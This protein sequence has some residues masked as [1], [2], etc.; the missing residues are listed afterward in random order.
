MIIKIKHTIHL[1][2]LENQIIAFFAGKREAEIYSLDAMFIMNIVG[3]T[4][5]EVYASLSSGD[6]KQIKA[7]DD[8]LYTAE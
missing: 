3:V 4:E 6:I 1:I 7:K 5:K 8:V 2:Y